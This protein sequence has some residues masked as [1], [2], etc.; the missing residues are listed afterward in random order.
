MMAPELLR[1]PRFSVVIPTYNRGRMIVETLHSVL[2]QTCRDFEVIVV[3]DG[4]TDDTLEHLR[5]FGDA[6]QVAQQSNAGPGAARNAGAAR[7]S[8]EYLTFLDSDDLWFPWSLATYARV[9][10]ESGAPSFVAGCPLRFQDGRPLPPAVE[11]APVT[12]SFENYLASG[13]EWRWWG[14]SSFV[15]RRDVFQRSGG[16]VAKPINGEDADLTLRLGCEPGFVQITAPA[17]FAYRDHA[18]NIMANLD[19]S[20]QGVFH[21]LENDSRGAYPGT[22]RD[23][24]AQRGRILTRHVRPASLD[25]LRAG[26]IGDAVAMYRATFGRNVRERR[27]KY[28]VG[29]PWLLIRSLIVGRPSKSRAPAESRSKDETFDPRPDRLSP[30]ERT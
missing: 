23:E 22:S 14:V 11:S 4:S 19:K 1:T 3:D 7:A 5:S 6:V 26:R 17:T 25:C 28:L 9:I 30:V 27:W 12:R 21:L 13:D 18:S 15:I 16:F 10:D 8:G 24:A 20:V 29:F 2:S